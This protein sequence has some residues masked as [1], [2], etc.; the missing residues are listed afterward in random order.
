MSWLNLPALLQFYE[1][2]QV[3]GVTVD[4]VGRGEDEDRLRSKPARCFQQHKCAVRVYRKIHL[5]IFCRPIMR[6]LRGGMDDE[7]YFR[8]I[9]LKDFI[10]GFLV[11][12]VDVLVDIPAGELLPK[13]ITIPLGRGARAK[14]RSSQIVVDPNDGEVLS[15]E[16]ANRLGAD[17][18]SRA[19]DNSYW[20]HSPCFAA[21]T[22]SIK[23]CGPVAKKSWPCCTTT[24]PW[25]PGT[26]Y[27]FRIYE[28]IT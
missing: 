16:E 26:C 4:F 7:F 21:V 13:A 5:G 10:D 9:L 2:Q 12:Y 27:I 23:G 24:W 8:G 11:S 3:W 15:G 22:F 1:R 28:V 6:G 14:E 25:L 18:S 20:H 17:Q 19:C